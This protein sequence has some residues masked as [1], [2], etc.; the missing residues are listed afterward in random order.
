MTGFT[1]L[2]FQQLYM[3]VTAFLFVVKGRTFDM[4]AITVQSIEMGGD[5][6][7]LTPE[8]PAVDEVFHDFLL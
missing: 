7:D 8:N 3:Y 2:K 4:I 5:V 6:A 1:Q